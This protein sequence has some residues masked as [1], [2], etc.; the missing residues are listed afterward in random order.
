MP[1][2]IGIGESM[3]WFDLKQTVVYVF[4]KSDSGLKNAVFIVKKLHCLL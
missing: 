2:A 3:Q 1:Q 4:S